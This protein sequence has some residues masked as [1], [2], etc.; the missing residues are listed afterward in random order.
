MEYEDIVEAVL[1]LLGHKATQQIINDVYCEVVIR[2]VDFN[3]GFASVVAKAAGMAPT[4]LKREL[5]A[6]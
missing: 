4:S 6:A 3:G 1:I 5:V 2:R